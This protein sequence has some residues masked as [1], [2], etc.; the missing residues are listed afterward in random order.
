MKTLEYNE[1]SKRQPNLEFQSSCG[2]RRSQGSAHAASFALGNL[3]VEEYT[4]RNSLSLS[5]QQTL[6]YFIRTSLQR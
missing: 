6:I 1:S 2:Q 5:T 4:R 3:P